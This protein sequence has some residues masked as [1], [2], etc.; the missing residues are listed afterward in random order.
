M[1]ATYKLTPEQ[2]R[3]EWLADLRSGKF[4][5]GRSY[6]CTPEPAGGES[7][8]CLGVGCETMRRCEGESA[9]DKQLTFS[10]TIRYGNDSAAVAP[11]AFVEWVG[12]SDNIGQYEG[13]SLVTLNDGDEM[14]F[15]KIA[16][17]IESKP[18]GLFTS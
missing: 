14:P 2:A 18:E 9:L 3:K 15:D 8:C 17:V 7:F 6:L 10:G 1:T 11:D 13:R 16:D 4:K 12:L 5:Q